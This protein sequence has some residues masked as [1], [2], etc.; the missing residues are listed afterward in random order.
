[1]TFYVRCHTCHTP[2]YNQGEFM[3]EV[4]NFINQ[5]KSEEEKNKIMPVLLE[6]YGYT[7]LCC[8]MLALGTVSLHRKIER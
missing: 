3:D 5:N 1:M 7:R 4:Y 2:M 8:R 6:K